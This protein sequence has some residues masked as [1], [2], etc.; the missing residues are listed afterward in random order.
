MQAEIFLCFR[1]GEFSTG[2]GWEMICEAYCRNLWKERFCSSR[3]WYCCCCGEKIFSKAE[4]R[5]IG[6][7]NVVPSAEARSLRK[8]PERRS[9]FVELVLRETKRVLKATC[10][11]LL[12]EDKRGL[13]CINAGIDKS[14]IEGN[15]NFALLPEDPDCSASDCRSRL[16]GLTGKKFGRCHLRILIVVLS[17]VASELCNRSL[18]HKPFQRLSG[19]E[20]SFRACFEG[21]ERWP[22]WM[23]SQLLQSCWWDTG[24]EA[25]AYCHTE[26]IERIDE[27]KRRLR[28]QWVVHI[29][30]RRFVQWSLVRMIITPIRACCLLLT[31]YAADEACVDWDNLW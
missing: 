15:E 20:G 25:D 28:N 7:R 6:V 23:R 24:T 14:N 30:E 29:R 10:E 17:G 19:E 5:V 22:S 18:W 9:K 3:T 2:R 27:G 21:Q 13:V 4:G 12:V 8:W 31:M 16:E 1:F 11:I 26:R